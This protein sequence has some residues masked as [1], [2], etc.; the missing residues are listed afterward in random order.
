MSA[1]GGSSDR[2]PVSHGT[3]RG[4][5]AGARQPCSRQARANGVNTW[6]G[7]PS[8]LVTRP[9][10]TAYGEPVR[11]SGTSPRACSTAASRS[12]P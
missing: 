11:T 10:V 1:D 5:G 7:V 9:G 4:R 8:R 6:K 12:R 2:T 3:S